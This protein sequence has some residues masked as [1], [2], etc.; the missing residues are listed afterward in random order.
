MHGTLPLGRARSN[1]RGPKSRARNIDPQPIVFR[2]VARLAFPH[3]T[4]AAL[5]H[6]TG[7]ARSTIQT[8]LA[9]EHEPPA[10]VMAIV[11]AEIM[12]RLAGQ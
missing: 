8:W 2:D 6:V 3:K 11:F 5:G 4:T 7:C 1:R 12:R 10:R 9:G